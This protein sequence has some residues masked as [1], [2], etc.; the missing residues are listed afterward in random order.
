MPDKQ[1]YQRRVRDMRAIIQRVLS[2][3]VTVEGNL[4][5]SIGPGLMC[6]IG[7][8]REDTPE[9]RD[10]IIR[11]IL[12]A[13]LFSGDGKGWNKSVT[14]MDYEVLLVS[15]FTLYAI[16]KGNKPDFHLAMGPETSKL[17]YSDFVDLVK[18]GYQKEKVKD[19]LFGAKMEVQLV[20]DGPV[21]LVVDSREK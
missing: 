13:R 21:T 6:L 17:F 5:S 7:I 3:S 12:N 10:Y 20:N 15:Q 11:K 19:G 16:L 18:L 4:I 8:N 2:A 14:Q 9:D 1:W